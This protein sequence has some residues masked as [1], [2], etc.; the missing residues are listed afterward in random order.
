MSMNGLPG[1]PKQFSVR[2]IKVRPRIY[3]IR[4]NG[5]LSRSEYQGPLLFRALHRY[6]REIMGNVVRQVKF[7]IYLTIAYL[8]LEI[9]RVLHEIAN[10]IIGWLV[11]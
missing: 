7:L 5:G 9:V 3:R 8:S 6:T 2:S 10:M 4:T 11:K 1:T